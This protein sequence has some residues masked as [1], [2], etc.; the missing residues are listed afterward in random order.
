MSQT[1]SETAGHL[2][3]NAAEELKANPGQWQAYE[4]KG[5][6]VILAGPGSGKT[7]TLTIKMARILA[8]DIRPPQGVACITYNSECARELERRLDKLG[9]AINDRIFI[10]TVHSFCLKHIVLPYAHL[11]GYPLPAGWRVA[12]SGEQNRIFE[13]VFNNSP[14][15]HEDKDYWRI[16]MDRFRRTVLDRNSEEWNNEPDLSCLVERYE[17]KLRSEGLIDFDDMV[18]IGLRLLKKNKWIGKLIKS[19]FPVLVVDEY[20]DLG[21]PLHQIVLHLC[22]QHRIRLIAVG[23]PDQ[24]IY[25]FTGAKPELLRELARSDQIESVQLRINYRCAKRIAVASQGT[26]GGDITYDVPPDTSEGVVLFYNCNDMEHQAATIFQGIIPQVL[27]RR[28]NLKLGNIAVLYA[29]KNIGDIMA[30]AASANGMKYIRIDQNAPYQ[31]TPLTRWLEECAAWCSGGWLKGQPRLSSLIQR[32]L[33]FNKSVSRDQRFLYLRK[34]F[35]RFLW[36]TRNN[37]EISLRDWLFQMHER[38]LKPM[39]EREMTMN[40]ESLAFQ[41]LQNACGENGKMFDFTVKTFAGQGGSPDHLNLITLHSAKGREFDVVIIPGMDAG[42]FPSKYATGQ[43]KQEALRLF[44]VGVTRAINELHIL[45]S[46][47]PSEF[48]IRFSDSLPPS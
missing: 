20:Q 22:F 48:V 21:V 19:K 24:S 46:N 2:Y 25:G 13:S 14:V 31:K 12:N 37:P 42:R 16:N 39:F 40:D 27:Q 38:C 35:V 3:R 26:L 36:E 18:L 28:N 17:A 30:E 1:S 5:N 23:D 41:K 45:Y 6:C 44:Y 47:S 8:E 11:A 7:K 9:V 33:S 15:G 32:W 4:S 29:N 10:G 34:D 43:G